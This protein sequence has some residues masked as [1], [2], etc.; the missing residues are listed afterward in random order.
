MQNFKKWREAY[1]PNVKSQLVT[2]S[3]WMLKS[4]SSFLSSFDHIKSVNSYT[5][6]QWHVDSNFIL[7]CFLACFNK[8]LFVPLTTCNDHEIYFCW[9]STKTCSLRHSVWKWIWWLNI[10]QYSY[11]ANL[12][13]FKPA[14]VQST[15]THILAALV[16][17]HLHWQIHII[18][19]R[20]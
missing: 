13:F 9:R 3:N 20:I 10:V 16:L 2:L 18:A 11:H 1:I 6:L 12:P 8:H 14:T 7:K 4:L 17:Q 19:I 15:D 5:L